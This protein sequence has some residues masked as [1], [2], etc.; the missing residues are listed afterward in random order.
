MNLR[1]HLS[2]FHDAYHLFLQEEQYS[3]QTKAQVLSRKVWDLLMVL[4]TNP[5]I[6]KGFKDIGNVVRSFPIH[7]S[8][9]GPQ[10]YSSIPSLFISGK[11]RWLKLMAEL[12]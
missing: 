8:I 7:S 9:S 10:T 4:P 1:S 2:S 12:G 6:L 5:E 11:R 3:L